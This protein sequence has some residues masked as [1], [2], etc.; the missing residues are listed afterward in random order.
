MLSAK[1]RER[2]LTQT[3]LASRIKRTRGLV[4]NWLSGRSQ[5]SDEDVRALSRVFKVHV[6]DWF[7]TSTPSEPCTKEDA[8]EIL[9]ALN[10]LEVKMDTIMKLGLSRS[11]LEAQGKPPD[12]SENPP[13]AEPV[14]PV[15][16]KQ[17][18]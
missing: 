7:T 4:V 13:D 12:V 16:D 15:D 8:A 6:A 3:E 9:A 5:P 11:Q 2:E 1:L 17:A 14:E 18:K 10:R